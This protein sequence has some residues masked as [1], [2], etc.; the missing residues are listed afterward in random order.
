MQLP[1]P[2]WIMVFYNQAAEAYNLHLRGLVLDQMAALPG[3]R[4]GVAHG[5]WSGAKNL[6]G[7]A[8]TRELQQFIRDKLPPERWAL[9]GWG[10][11]MEEGNSIGT[12]DHAKSYQG[13]ENQ[14]SGVYYVQS[15]RY[16]GELLVAGRTIKPVPGM[17]VLFRAD[18][19]HAVSPIHRQ[20]PSSEPMQRISIAFNAKLV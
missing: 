3:S 4:L 15:P 12:H 14:F 2:G 8:E 16:S 19:K 18:E 6:F 1:A 7:K 17:L 9:E 13:G 20:P 5:G 11:V 10:T